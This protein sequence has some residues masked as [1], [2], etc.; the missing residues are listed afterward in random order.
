[1][2]CPRLTLVAGIAA[3]LVSAFA[4]PAVAAPTEAQGTDDVRPLP[5]MW[6]PPPGVV[7]LSPC[8]PYMGEHW[9]NPATFPLGPIYTVDRGRLISIEYMIAQA[10]FAAGRSWLDLKFLY[11]GMPLIIQHANIEFLPEGHDGFAVPHYDMHFH[12]VTHADERA[13]TCV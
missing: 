6:N 4:A 11:W 8:V 10:D 9:A 3:L 13:I 2:L 7:Q 12:L 5:V 1:M